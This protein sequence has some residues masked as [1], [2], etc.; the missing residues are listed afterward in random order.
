MK[1]AIAGVLLLIAFSR[2]SSPAAPVAPIGG[3]VSQP[4]TGNP[5]ADH[6][7]VIPQSLSQLASTIPSYDIPGSI[8]S[9]LPQTS[10]VGSTPAMPVPTPVY[11]PGACGARPFRSDYGDD[12][13]SYTYDVGQWNECLSTAP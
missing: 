4:I 7:N 8:Q 9:S 6:A 1:F 12:V 11:S 5:A 13:A 3:A 2:R 10:L